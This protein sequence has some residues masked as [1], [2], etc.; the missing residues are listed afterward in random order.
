MGSYT[1]DNFITLV[2]K[3]DAAQ[4][5]YIGLDAHSKTCTGVVMDSKGKILKKEVFPT[6][7]RELLRFVDSVKRPRVLTFEEMNI[8]QWLY[9]L[10]KDR[11]DQVQVAHA[12]HLTKQRGAKTDFLDAQRL[13]QETRLGTITNVYH[14]DGPMFELR[15]LVKSHQDFT[16]DMVKSMNRYKAF[17]R[18]RGLFRHDKSVY[19]DESLLEAIKKPNDRFVAENIFRH[20]T[21]TRE[22]KKSYEEK[23]QAIAKKWPIIS[24]LCDIP[25]IGFLRATMI[26]SII[27]SGD[28]FTDKHKL[29]AYCG[30]VRHKEISD[31]K[32]YG[33]KKIKGSS[34]LKC[35]FTGAATSVLCGNSSLRVYY[36]RLRSK[37]VS[38]RDAKRAVARK[39]A[40]IVLMIMKTGKSY[41]ERV[42]IANEETRSDIT[43]SH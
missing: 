15:A 37:G 24:K 28:R 8:A 33:N 23:L 18:A 12:P 3:E 32:V 19:S 41:D 35:V 29:W 11:V 25:G 36:D 14:D 2:S 20:I 17:L 27:C 34:D 10:L 13:A 42:A 22:I 21:A 26:V 5:Q 40:A 30:L 43:T 39:I 31:G 6:S 4:T 7:E 38:D 1:R 9:V 16:K